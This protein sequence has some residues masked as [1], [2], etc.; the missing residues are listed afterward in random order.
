MKPST[1]IIAGRPQRRRKKKIANESE[2]NIA[3]INMILKEVYDKTPMQNETQPFRLKPLWKQLLPL[4]ELS[5]TLIPKRAFEGGETSTKCPKN[6]T[7]ACHTT[8]DS[9]WA[10]RPEEWIHPTQKHSKELVGNI[11]GDANLPFW[12]FN[13]LN[14]FHINPPR[15]PLSFAHY[16]DCW[17]RMQ[18]L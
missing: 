10:Q 9:L 15:L 7:L 5:N 13:L 17:L 14:I 16:F 8:A 2:K 4:L 6:Q 3:S 11:Y 18:V 1:H 12:P